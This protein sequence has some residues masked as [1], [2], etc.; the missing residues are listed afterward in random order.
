MI[1]AIDGLIVL[2]IYPLAVLIREN[3]ELSKIDSELVFMRSLIVLSIYLISFLLFGT[4]KSVIRQTGLRDSYLVIKGVLVA[5]SFLIVTSILA[6]HLQYSPVLHFSKGT[7]TIHFFTVLFFLLSFRFGVKASFVKMRDIIYAKKMTSIIIYGSG[8]LGEIT[9][10]S[11]RR[12]VN[13]TYLIHCFI[14]DNESKQGK[15]QDGVPILPMETV[16]NE[17]YIIKHKISSLIIAINKLSARKKRAIIERCISL[18]IQVKMVPAIDSWIQND[19][20]F[21]SIKPVAIEDLLGREPISLENHTIARELKGKVILITGA[22]GSIGKEITRQVIHYQPQKVVLVDIAESAVYELQ[23]EISRKLPQLY[24][25][26]DFVILD[27]TRRD[28]LEA[29][30]EKVKPSIIYHAA[31]Y[32]H[33]PLMEQFP[34]ESAR[35]NIVGTRNLVDLASK[36]DVEKFVFISTDKAINP[37]NVMGATK[38]VAEMYVQTK[39]EDNLIAT[40]F[41]T[42]RF[43]NV[44]GSNGSVVP[45]FR[46]QIEDGGPIMVTH[47]EVTRYFMT[48]PEACNLVLEAGAMGENGQILVFDM[49]DSIKIIDLAHKMIQLMGLEPDKD[50]KVIYTGLRPGEKLREELISA[51][52]ETMATHHK[53]ILIS[54]S[55]VRNHSVLAEGINKIQE[56]I[57]NNDTWAVVKQMKSMV[58]E[59]VSKN[60]KFETLDQISASRIDKVQPF[61]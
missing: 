5:Y 53:K 54:K 44:L 42:T 56:G 47:P 18:N 11:L 9:R 23:M 3:F 24:S 40:K 48:I 16:L 59:Y 17:E 20:S 10:A 4:Y 13:N 25:L 12:E 45:L 41:I 19:F 21:E 32:K 36:Y 14:D 37:T 2:C 55:V 7:L 6:Y 8:E 15:K 28:A 58:P 38:R 34:L 49:G 50:V 39:N 1:L 35:V 33:V 43:G 61:R 22:A 26:C 29:L 57:Y 60:S 27:I 31:A 46:K 52:E 30:I 51:S